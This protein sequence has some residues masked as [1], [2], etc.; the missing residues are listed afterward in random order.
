MNE[1]DSMTGQLRKV[2]PQVS[3]TKSSAVPATAPAPSPASG[4]VL[5]PYS[6]PMEY[7]SQSDNFTLLVELLDSAAANLSGVLLSSCVLM[8]LF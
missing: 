1:F 5:S 6:V 8:V 3:T 2:M 4:T 7:L